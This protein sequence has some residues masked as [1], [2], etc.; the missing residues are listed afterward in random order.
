MIQKAKHITDCFGT[1]LCWHIIRI[2]VSKTDCLYGRSYM[3]CSVNHIGATSSPEY[4]GWFMP[5]Q[6]MIKPLKHNLLNYQGF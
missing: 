1:F 5:E 3:D 2:E 4:K 6:N